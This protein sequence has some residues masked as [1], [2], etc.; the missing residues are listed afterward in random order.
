MTIP[1]APFLSSDYGNTANASPSPALRYDV[2]CQ[3]GSGS[4]YLADTQEKGAAV[5]T[6]STPPRMPRV[7]AARAAGHCVDAIS[8]HLCRFSRRFRRRRRKAAST[9]TL[10]RPAHCQ[11]NR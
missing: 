11:L 3:G 10:P 6:S 8:L 7:Q 9:A 1:T 4:C 5:K 2:T